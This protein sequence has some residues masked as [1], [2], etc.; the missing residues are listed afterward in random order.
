MYVHIALILNS[1][2]PRKLTVCTYRSYL[3]LHKSQK[4]YI[5]IEFQLKTYIYYRIFDLVFSQETILVHKE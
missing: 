3:K 5:L 2:N 4:T 1:T